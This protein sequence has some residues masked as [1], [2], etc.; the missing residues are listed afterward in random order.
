ML[1]DFWDVLTNAVMLVG[2]G[3]TADTLV[4]NSIRQKYSELTFQYRENFVSESAQVIVDLFSIVF[5]GKNGRISILRSLLAS[6]VLFLTLSVIVSSVAGRS[7][8]QLFTNASPE[9]LIGLGAVIV[10]NGIGD[11]LSL[12]QT[13]F[14][15][16]K[17]IGSNRIVQLIGLLVDIVLTFIII[18]GFIAIF[19]WTLAKI[20]GRTS[21]EGWRPILWQMCHQANSTFI[22]FAENP[23]DYLETCSPI[24]RS[25]PN[26]S[27][28]APNFEHI[29]N[30]TALLT[31]FATTAWLLLFFVAQVCLGPLRFLF[32]KFTKS[33]TKHI[34]YKRFPFSITS[35]FFGLFYL[36]LAL[37]STLLT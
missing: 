9:N 6:L 20:D 32:A 17:L 15:M 4:R 10:A 11:Y 24:M 27:G 21:W 13:K 18:A 2:V 12:I 37:L 30:A 3:V 29:F 33:I 25:D 8:V 14:F 7:L 35:L 19:F 16:K 5:E 23:K 22:V 28:P 36:V 26:I 31:T 1:G 34:N